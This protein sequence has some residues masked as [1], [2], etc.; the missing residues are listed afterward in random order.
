MEVIAMKQITLI[1]L[2]SG[3]SVLYPLKMEI[4]DEKADGYHRQSL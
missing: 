2:S 4:E 1:D 3:Q